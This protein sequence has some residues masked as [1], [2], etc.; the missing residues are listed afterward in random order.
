MLP[1]HPWQRNHLNRVVPLI[2]GFWN[3]HGCQ[4]GAINPVL[5]NGDGRTGGVGPPCNQQSG[6]SDGLRSDGSR[7]DG[8]AVGERHVFDAGESFILKP[9]VLGIQQR[10]VGQL[11]EIV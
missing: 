10:R 11:I 3:R 5:P 8:S 2:T 1:L 9:E 6:R 4:N 7:S